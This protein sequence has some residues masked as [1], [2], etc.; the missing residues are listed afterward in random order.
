MHSK[1][2]SLGLVSLLCIALTGAQGPA[3]AAA[4]PVKTG[5]VVMKTTKGSFKI[6][7]PGDVNAFGKIQ[8]SFKG[9]LLIIG[10][11]GKI[12][13]VPSAGLR[14]EYKNDKRQRIEYFGEG[15]VTLDGKFR[16]IQFL[17]RNLNL[18]WTEAYGICRVYGQFDKDGNTGT[19]T[20][21]GDQ[22][23]YWGSDGTTFTVPPRT[24]NAV[25]PPIKVKP[26]GS[27]G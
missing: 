7:S 18:S 25:V 10:Y 2:F 17:G 21:K 22:E 8:M 20:V 16:A 1:F 24:N 12:P 23:R 19:F 14:V 4:V 13:I 27:G 11:D 3:S 5:E 9:S 15:T 6:T 26:K